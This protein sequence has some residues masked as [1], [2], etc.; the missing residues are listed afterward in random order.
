M[1]SQDEYNE[2]LKEEVRQFRLRWSDLYSGDGEELAERDANHPP[3]VL[4]W[5]LDDVCKEIARY[6]SAMPKAENETQRL[7]DTMNTVIT[8]MKMT[9]VRFFRMGQETIHILPYDRLSPCPCEKLFD[10]ELTDFL[11][12]AIG[13]EKLPPREKKTVDKEERDHKFKD[14]RHPREE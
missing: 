5:V 2:A 9:A 10:D 12:S 11:T 14:K 4:G 13:T 7:E 6:L 3:A 1:G 8:Y